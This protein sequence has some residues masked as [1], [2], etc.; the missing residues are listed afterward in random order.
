VAYESRMDGQCPEL[1]LLC[2]APVTDVLPALRQRAI[3]VNN[4]TMSRGDVSNSSVGGVWTMSLKSKRLAGTF[5]VRIAAEIATFRA[6]YNSIPPLRR[7]AHTARF[8][9]VIGDHTNSAVSK[10]VLVL[11]P[12]RAASGARLGAG[13]PTGF[14]RG[15]APQKPANFSCLVR[16]SA[17]LS[18]KA[19]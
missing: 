15:L 8:E 10:A 14:L 5:R 4:R 9:A 19:A 16:A 17:Y 7:G 1:R 11:G 12:G 6:V 2:V 18:H 3:S 13:S